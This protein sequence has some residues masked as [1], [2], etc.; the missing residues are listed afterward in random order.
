MASTSLEEKRKK[1]ITA[2]QVLQ[3]LQV[4]TV[5]VDVLLL[6]SV[7]VTYDVQMRMI[8]VR[9]SSGEGPRP[10]SVSKPNMDANELS[11]SPMK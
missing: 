1:K 6:V 10:S 7:L 3:V 2:Q 4:A 8:L 5:D 9:E 11:K